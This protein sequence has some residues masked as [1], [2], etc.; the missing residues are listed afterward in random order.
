MAARS[1]HS[2]DAAADAIV[3]DAGR[4]MAGAI[5]NHKFA[6]VALIP[7]FASEGVTSSHM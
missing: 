2:E 3:M 5:S 1:S 6:S 4:K 7:K